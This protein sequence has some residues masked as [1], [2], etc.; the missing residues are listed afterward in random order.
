MVENDGATVTTFLAIGTQ[1][2]RS[3]SGLCLLLMSPS[4][5][6]QATDI[7]P[8]NCG[9]GGCESPEWGSAVSVKMPQLR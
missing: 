3:G 1:P 9:S 7:A 2:Q 8:P 6:E 4:S 5:D